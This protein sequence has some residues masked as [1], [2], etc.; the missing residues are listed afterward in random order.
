MIAKLLKLLTAKKLTERIFNIVL[1]S[2]G[3]GGLVIFILF[4]IN[5]VRREGY[6]IIDLVVPP[7]EK[8]STEEYGYGCHIN[9]YRCQPEMI[10]I[11]RLE[12]QG[13]Q[14]YMKYVK[15]KLIDKD[16][17]T[18][19]SGL[20]NNLSGLKVGEYVTF[21]NGSDYIINS[22]DPENDQPAD[23]PAIR[24]DPAEFDRGAVA[25]MA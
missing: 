11:I 12:G 21:D 8:I 17:V 5:M 3:L 22:L 23:C 13:A 15:Y 16:N 9:G 6:Q 7:L 24:K 1:L 10:Y 4:I 25:L 19:Y 18:R 14:H 2:I 20:Y